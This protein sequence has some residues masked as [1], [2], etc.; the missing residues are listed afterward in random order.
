MQRDPATG[1]LILLSLEGPDRP[2]H[3][4]SHAGMT[5]AGVFGCLILSL[6]FQIGFVQLWV[7]SR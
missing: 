7:G 3:P 1:R 5:A 2:I 6:P 4:S